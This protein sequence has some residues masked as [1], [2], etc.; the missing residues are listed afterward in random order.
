[1]REKKRTVLIV[2]DNREMTSI[3]SLILESD[4]YETSGAFTGR[5]ALEKVAADSPDLLL[6]DLNL[7]DLR[8][9]E[10]L[11]RVRE[12]HEDTAVIIITGFGSEQVA[13]DLM[14]AGAV[15]F[16]SKPFQ[17]ETL[18][19]AVKSALKIRDDLIEEK[20]HEGYSSLEKFFPFLA[21]EVR[22]PLHAIG[23]AIA[24]IQRRCNR[25]DPLLAQSIQIIQEEVQHLSEFVQECL[26]F[27]RPPVASRYA[28]VEIRELLS[29]VINVVSYMFEHLLEK[30]RITMDLDPKLPKIHANY[31]EI[32]Q[33]FL[34]IA[35]N[36]FEA[37]P[38]GGALVISA[39]PRVDGG[40]EWIRIVFSDSGAGIKPEDA[41]AL[42]SPFFTTK[43]RGTG[44]GL[45]LSKRIIEERHQGRIDVESEEGKGTSVIVELPVEMKETTV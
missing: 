34:N 31:E 18:L 25:E 9:E 37:M 35:K 23:G 7:P 10:V 3:V 21:H 12:T 29:A 20:R 11:K 14:K 24:I 38:E 17:R 45:A 2:D 16:I 32:K 26:D 42:F 30:T 28:S 36:A 19:K 27:V 1:M 6:L 41:R 44:L 13:V 22:N 33:A 39:R 40:S 4:G 15:D 8:G 5:E 43:L